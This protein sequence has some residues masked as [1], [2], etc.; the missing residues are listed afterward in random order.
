[1]SVIQTIRARVIQ[2]LREQ[3][4]SAN[5]RLASKHAVLTGN[6]ALAK[7]MCY[8]L[9][10]FATAKT[11][12]VMAKSMKKI[13]L[14]RTV[15]LDNDAMAAS[16][17]VMRRLAPQV[18]VMRWALV[19]RLLTRSVEQVERLAR[20]VLKERCAT[21]ESAFVTRHLAPTVV[22]IAKASAKLETPM[23]AVGKMVL[24]VRLAQADK[25]VILS[26]KC[27]AVVQILVQQVV[28]MR[29]ASVP[30]RL[31]LLVVSAE[32]LVLLAIP[33]LQMFVTTAPV[34]AD[35]AQLA[36]RVRLV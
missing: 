28:V 17:L 21:L 35:R 11:T 24:L 13:L 36:L 25:H 29:T 32:T 10:R 18:A 2:V 7:G 14:R 20:L 22:V 6:G 31:S 30:R 12:T 34:S 33:S 27:V 5:V 9:K 26:R 19:R 8:L 4:A 3:M 16:V 15:L 1:M 23:Q